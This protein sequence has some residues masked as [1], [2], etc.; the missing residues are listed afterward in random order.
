MML[1]QTV[2]TQYPPL[3]VP[4]CTPSID[5]HRHHHKHSL[6]ARSR[7]A[8]FS[9]LPNSTVSLTTFQ[10]F[11]TPASSI[12]DGYT[13]KNRHTHGTCGLQAYAQYSRRSFLANTYT[14]ILYPPFWRDVTRSHPNARENRLADM[15][16]WSLAACCVLVIIDHRPKAVFEFS[17]K[18]D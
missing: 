2:K 1:V 13:P 3:L 7:T 14:Y 10:S 8:Q 17:N 18:A 12:S 4:P 11:Y 9:L 5:S 16:L 6:K 15:A